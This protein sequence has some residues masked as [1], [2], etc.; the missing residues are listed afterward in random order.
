[1]KPLRSLLLFAV[2]LL[3]QALPVSLLAADAPAAATV[4]L[5]Q[6][7]ASDLLKHLV[8]M[9]LTFFN[10]PAEGNTGV[11]YLIAALALV[12]SFLL[13][14]VVTRIIF[15]ILKK[16]AERTETTLDDKLFPQMEAPTAALITVIGVFVSISVLTLS[17]GLVRT[18][19]FG[20]AAAFSLVI[21][22]AFFAPSTPSSITPMRSRFK[23]RWASRPSCRGSRRR[24]S[25][26]SSSSAC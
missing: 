12:V 25:R 14:H 21:S 8:A 15:R 13:R 6:A 4:P 1:M 20:F 11:H 22:G 7:P 2:L 5:T 24:S 17:P 19:N 26:S 9:V 23:S 3:S 18:V 16:F 10:L